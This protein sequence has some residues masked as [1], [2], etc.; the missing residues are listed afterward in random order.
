[1][2]TKRRAEIIQFNKVKVQIPLLTEVHLQIWNKMLLYPLFLFLFFHN[3][4]TV[5][6]V[7]SQI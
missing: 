7:I 5:A 4:K 2:Q 6:V 1:M 3:Q